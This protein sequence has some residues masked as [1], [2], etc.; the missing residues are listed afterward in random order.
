MPQT[1]NTN[2][3]SL[4]AQRNLNKS[5]SSLQTSL[6]RLSSGLRINSAKDDAAG[7]AISSRMTSQINGLNQA[8]RNAND[9]ISLA[10]TAEGALDESTNLMQRIRTLS[11][12]SANATNTT[13]DRAALN[14]EVNQLVA[15]IDRIAQTTQ[16]NNQNILDGTFA[17]AQFQVGAN[18]NQVISFG[19]QGATT[20]L[21]GSY[22]A[23]N[24]GAVD[25]TAFDGANFQI[26]GVDVGASIATSAAGVTDSSAAAKATAI[27][28]V[29]SQTGVTAI[30]S[31]SVTGIAPVAGQALANG[32]LVINGVAV[33]SIA[34]GDDAVTQ[35][36]N[37]ATQI[38]LISNQTGVAATVNAST[39]AITLAASDGRDI[40]ISAGNA[41]DA[42]VVTDIFNSTGLDA[43]DEAD[44]TG[45]ATRDLVL[46]VSD[47]V[48]AADTGATNEIVFGDTLVIDGLTY[49]F[50]D[51]AG[52]ETAGNIAVV[53]DAADTTDTVGA[54]LQSAIN[55]QNPSST[56][57]TASYAAGS[58][59]LTLT[60]SLV[61]AAG[62][63]VDETG[64]TDAAAVD[65]SGAVADGTDAAGTTAVDNRGTLAIVSDSN[66][67]FGG[68][69]AQL[70]A[71][72]LQNSS[73][74]L[75]AIDT[76][77]IST[78][79]GANN[80]ISI[81]DG[82][83]AQV[84]SIRADLGALQN[85]FSSTVNNLQTTSEN[86]S[87]ARSRILDTDFAMETANL[88]RTQIL[89]QAGT[90][91]LAQANALPQNVLSLLG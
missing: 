90:A 29:S 62:L 78:V 22:Q 68:T 88:T 25:G 7:L 70:T 35:G 58:D 80:A 69:S 37:A 1:I 72:G 21:L 54:A 42:T 26:N 11:L 83:L 41:A 64:M 33:G 50:V 63:A 49:E 30:A 67:T 17:S 19:I 32:D 71:A 91:M 51:N 56:T 59:T 6:Q 13:S 39:G 5:Q 60:Q 28:S 55:G 47:G 82:A 84:N 75:S 65:S 31:N 2:V 15:E 76:L 40:Q 12:Q 27:N 81:L 16:F 74:A 4:N 46:D 48:V 18:A 77:D 89:Q 73:T 52:D 45:N 79:A 43:A 44:P 3:S 86:V 24:V 10:Q 57:V 14:A 9:G 36:N 34:A 23:T 85:R 66:F 61:G 38:N 87:A 20:N 8:M 53:L